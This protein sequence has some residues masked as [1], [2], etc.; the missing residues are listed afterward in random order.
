MSG[1]PQRS[2]HEAEELLAQQLDEL[3]SR[4]S[5]L[6]DA[7]IHAVAAWKLMHAFEFEAAVLAWDRVI[8]AEPRSLEA[9]FQRGLCLL[10]L[11]RFD[12][13]A[14]AFG[15]SMELDAA[16]RGDPDSEALDWIEDDPAYR[17]G[18]CRHAQ[19]D[20]EA[21]ISAYE[22]S[23][24]RNTVAGHALREIVRCRLAQDR[25]QDALDA[26]VRLAARAMSIAHRAEV[27]ALRADAERML[28]AAAG[29]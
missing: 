23:A 16:L 3:E 20:L 21:A 8:G 27:Q 22:E 17:L 19:G 15:A 13:A 2:P 24:R 28:R 25:P 12:E 26:L 9:V 1:A 5:A 7:G 29:G 14:V 11:S 18:N 10:E 4:R 6:G